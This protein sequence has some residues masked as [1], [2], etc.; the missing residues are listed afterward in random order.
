[1]QW[2]RTVARAELECMV[3]CAQ[4]A[5]TENCTT[6][7]K[8]KLTWG[9]LEKLPPPLAATKMPLNDSA[10]F[11]LRFTGVHGAAGLDQQ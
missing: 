7:V 5:A 10:L 6:G 3:V 9:D 4:S 11:P 2:E 1:M 8:A